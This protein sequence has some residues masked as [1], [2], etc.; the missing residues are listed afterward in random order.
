MQRTVLVFVPE[1]IY[2]PRSGSHQR[3]LEVLSGLGELGC[4]VTLASSS[5]SPSTR[6]DIESIKSIEG[7]WADKLYTREL[8]PIDI[9]YTR[10]LRKAYKLAG[11]TA[12]LDS[13]SRTPPG[14]RRWFKRIF[15]DVNPDAILLNHGHWD[16]LL[17]HSSMLATTALETVDIKTL[18]F[19]MKRAIQQYIS[20]EPMNPERIPDFVL[21][22][23][24][25]NKKHLRVDDSEFRI[26]DQY[27]YTVTISAQENEILRQHCS[28]TKV[29]YL[30]MTREPVTL[31]NSYDGNPI[32]PTAGH[33]FALHGYYYFV[34]KVLPRILEREPYFELKMT[35]T[36]CDCVFPQPG[37][38]MCG[39]VPDLQPLYKASSFLVAPILGGTGQPTKII[40][41]MAHGLGV[42]TLQYA[43]ELTSIRHGVNGL[44]ARSAEEFAE[45]T[46]QLW[47]DRDLCRRLGQ[48]ARETIATEYPRKRLVEGLAEIVG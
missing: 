42:V 40:E 14:V 7:K 19:S 43:A 13:K 38:S 25:Y 41:A 3:A 26:Y 8:S 15:E 18:N 1:N 5:L 29:L 28:K 20:R 23:D 31:E 9:G 10:L 11:K 4:K 47:R 17:E 6:W 22:E 33:M 37:I 2:P 35:G 21:D 48:A 27:D 44:V 45:Y 34:R 32:F 46:I 36:G 12:P 16:G 30:P 24:F 39:F